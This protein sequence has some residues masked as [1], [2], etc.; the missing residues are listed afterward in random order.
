MKQK[1]MLGRSS[2]TSLS[3]RVALCGALLLATS[4]RTSSEDI[5]RWA[6]TQQGPRKLVSVLTHA[7]YPPT[8]RV[9]AALTLI[10]MKPRGGRR[11]GIDQALEAL[12]VVPAEERELLLSA[13]VP[14][15]V[16]ALDRAQPGGGENDPS[17]PYKDAAYY[18][19]SPGEAQLVKSDA[20]KQAIKD[21]LVRWA[22]ADFN[23]RL[24]AQSQKVSMQQML[25]DLGAPSVVGLPELIAPNNPTNGRIAQLVSELGDQATKVRASQKLVE[26]AAFVTS[27]QWVETRRAQVVEAN[28]V[29]GFAVEDARLNEQMLR[30][31]EEEEFRLF[32]SMRQVKQSPAINYLLQFA[33]DPTRIEKQRAGALAALERGLDAENPSD[34]AR[35]LAI[36]S[37]DTPEL[38]RGTAF[39][40]LG[41]LP[42][43]KVAADL[44]AL[45]SHSDWR[46]RW[47]AASLLLEMSTTDQVPE[48]MDHLNKVEHQS[49]T[50]P[51]SYGRQL[52]GMKG[53]RTP[54]ELANSYSSSSTGVPALLTALGYYYALGTA[55]DMKR[56]DSLAKDRH[57]VPGCAENAKDCEW[58]CGEKQ[59]ET[60]GDVVQH[61]VKPAIVARQTDA[62]PPP[63]AAP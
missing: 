21:A 50:E 3:T 2:W 6:N 49:L 18:L 28:K 20:Q 33:A 29:S 59:V 43:E 39:R 27:P 63:A 15:L 12:A 62:T 31:Q 58:Q 48:F 10:G 1:P 7:K 17:L 40:R 8:L 55:E 51:L 32:D 38:V 25:R 54:A 24:D 35:V 26:V 22:M 5:Q 13:L 16:S 9:E 60:V 53:T 36:I 56:L 41:E 19:I 44:Y 52:S 14:G 23:S 34:K 61:C 47:G 45:F 30:F 42:R 4:C 11:V 57:K 46:V 37:A